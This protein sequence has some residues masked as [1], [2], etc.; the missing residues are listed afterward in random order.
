MT[1]LRHH[2]PRPP[3][4]GALLLAGLA[5]LATLAACGP[6]AEETEEDRE[7]ILEAL[8]TYNERLSQAYAFADP[9]VLEGI[10]ATREINSVRTNIA[11]VASEGKRIVSELEQL[12][13]ED[14]NHYQASNAYVQTFEVWDIQVQA[15]GSDEVISRD[16]DQRSRVR[17]QVKREGGEWTV[18]WRQRLDD[19][20]AP[21]GGAAGP[22][23]PAG[24]GAGDAGGT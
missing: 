15:V 11:R 17:Y 5:L 12:T 16:R 6:S 4:A 9:S 19:T 8:E 14:L 7:A 20:G 2:P 18:V 22:D 24:E 21:S 13:I 10:A 23:A 1:R 3:R